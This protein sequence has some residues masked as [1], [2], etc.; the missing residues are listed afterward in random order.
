MQVRTRSAEPTSDTATAISRDELLGN[1]AGARSTLPPKPI[2][3]PRVLQKSYAHC[4]A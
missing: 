3:R 2:V 4:A 1:L